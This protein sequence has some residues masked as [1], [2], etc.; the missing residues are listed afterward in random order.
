MPHIAMANLIAGKRVVPEL[1]QNDFTA[2]NIVRRLSPLITDG[3]SRQSM[4]EELAELRRL[5]RARTS[6]RSGGAIAR[7]AEVT[8]ELLGTAH[9]ARV[10]ETVPH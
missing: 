5:L 2:S 10:A 3:A 4:M 7:V 8:L 6:G 1:I 9:A